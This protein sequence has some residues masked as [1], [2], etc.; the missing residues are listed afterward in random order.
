MFLH[1]VEGSFL[2]KIFVEVPHKN[3]FE[4]YQIGFF[5]FKII[6]LP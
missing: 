5:F 4:Y 1:K 3:T 2:F 6:V